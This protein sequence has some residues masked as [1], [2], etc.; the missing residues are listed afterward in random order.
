MLAL[1]STP[2]R[3]FTAGRPTRGRAQLA[4]RAAT[5]KEKGQTPG[6]KF[7]GAMQV[8]TEFGLPS[9]GR[10]LVRHCQH[11]CCP[12]A[13]TTPGLCR[14][15]TPQRWVRDDRFAGKSV[16]TVEPLR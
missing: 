6:F 1:L 9:R 4:V 14:S 15:R 11:L 12:L 7:D 3:P 16:T 5:Q 10:E 8:R 13:L 2:A